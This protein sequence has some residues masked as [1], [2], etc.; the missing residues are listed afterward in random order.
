[1]S[2]P[3]RSLRDRS[4]SLSHAARGRRAFLAGLLAVALTA[5][6]ATAGCGGDSADAG[7]DA[8][9][10]LVGYQ[11]FGGLSLVKARSAAPDATWS[12]FESGPALTEALKAGAIDIGQVGEAP[13]IFAAAGKIK[14]RIIGTSEPVPQGEAVLVKESKGFRS[15]ADLKGRTV[16]LN[17]GSNVNWLLVRLLEAHHMT[18]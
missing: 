15:F 17:K 18:L 16:A 3:A 12:L 8:G 5:T 2:H 13:P 6:G 7:A 1:M 14:F 4:R 9:K 10:L 11:R